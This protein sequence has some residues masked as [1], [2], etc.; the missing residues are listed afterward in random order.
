M[1][2]ILLKKL[3]ILAMS[4]QITKEYEGFKIDLF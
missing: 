2:S 3:Q 1:Y 4:K